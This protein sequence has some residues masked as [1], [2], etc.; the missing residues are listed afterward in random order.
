MHKIFVFFPKSAIV[1]W[2][3]CTE[4]NALLTLDNIMTLHYVILSRIWFGLVLLAQLTFQLS[5]SNG[6]NHSWCVS[7]YL[8]DGHIS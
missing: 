4:R 3:Y 2:C 5:L 1:R 7:V 8:W 6:Y